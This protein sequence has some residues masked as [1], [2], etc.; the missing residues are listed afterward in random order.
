MNTLNTPESRAL[1]KAAVEAEI[2]RLIP[3][4]RLEELA[5]HVLVR[6]NGLTKVII[7]TKIKA[8]VTGEGSAILG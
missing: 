1:R 8:G 6:Q 3:P 4:E 5:T 7:R 2:K